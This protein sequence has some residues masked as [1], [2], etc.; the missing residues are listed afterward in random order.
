[1]DVNGEKAKPPGAK[2]Q[3][4]NVYMWRLWSTD[5]MRHVC[6]ERRRDVEVWVPQTGQGGSGKI[7]TV[8]ISSGQA[9]K[10]LRVIG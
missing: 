8:C 2:K 7:S 6:A 3:S 4:F 9:D 1:M 10:L 5:D